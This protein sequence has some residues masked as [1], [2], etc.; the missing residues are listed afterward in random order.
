M[1]S[2]LDPDRVDDELKN[3][4][5]AKLKKDAFHFNRDEK[6][7]FVGNPLFLCLMIRTYDMIH[8]IPAQ[9]YIFYEK[10]YIAMASEYDSK[11]KRM[12]RPFFT[13]LNEKSF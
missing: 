9:R 6:R 10:T 13:K 2:K 3:D 5:I 1:I 4:F 8:D 12:T 11:T 7:N